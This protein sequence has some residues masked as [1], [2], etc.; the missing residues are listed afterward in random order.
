MTPPALILTALA[1][2][3]LAFLF[4]GLL[5]LCERLRLVRRGDTR[6]SEEVAG[7]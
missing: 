2:A 4:I 7:G 3:A 1:G 5:A 6:R